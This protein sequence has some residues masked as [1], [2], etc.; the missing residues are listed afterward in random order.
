MIASA[1]N[2]P[3]EG[4]DSRIT[5]YY[6]VEDRIDRLYQ[7]LTAK[8]QFSTTYMMQLQTD[9][10]SKSHYELYKLLVSH[11]GKISQS[12]QDVLEAIGDWDGYFDKDSRVAYLYHLVFVAL[13]N[14]LFELKPHLGGRSVITQSGLMPKFIMSVFENI[15]EDEQIKLINMAMA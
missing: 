11:S 2:K 12:N 9:T 14:N 3:Y 6:P 7:L 13:T 15:A 4:S 8:Y 5:W 10:F 1:N